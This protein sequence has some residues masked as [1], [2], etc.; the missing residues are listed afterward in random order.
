[1]Q[2][3]YPTFN[4]FLAHPTVDMR[5]S[6]VW[7][8]YPLDGFI[9]LFRAR[10]GHSLL[11]TPEMDSISL[12]DDFRQ[13]TSIVVDNDALLCYDWCDF[14]NDCFEEAK[15]WAHQRD[16]KLFYFKVMCTPA[17]IARGI[18]PVAQTVSR[19]E[20]LRQLPALRKF[21]GA[22]AEH[23]VTAIFRNT[24]HGQRIKAVKALRTLSDTSVMVWV[25]PH[26]RRVGPPKAVSGSLLSYEEH[27]QTQAKSSVCV[28][29]PGVCGDWT[30]RHME[31]LALGRCLVCP[32]P[33]CVLPENFAAQ[34][35]F[36]PCRRDL[37]DLA[38][39]V[40]WLL[41]HPAARNHIAQR[42]YAWWNKYATPAGL[43][44]YMLE[45][46]GKEL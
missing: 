28:A 41:D 1:M 17:H 15:E 9:E 42:G 26:P 21:V 10:G 5:S 45:T 24:D 16:S 4:A 34:G 7:H 44:R 29:M 43:A 22:C 31:V 27:L 8:D 14:Y 37:G 33:E 13:V 36:M 20:F 38:E 6:R 23:G 32:T 40:Q 30:W 46:A 18:L 25:Q 3:K 39:V 2:V 35:N 12:S 19:M 11:I